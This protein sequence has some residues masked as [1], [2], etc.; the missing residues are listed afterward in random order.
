P[1][2][3]RRDGRR[4]KSCWRTSGA[5]SIW[6]DRRCGSARSTPSSTRPERAEEPSRRLREPRVV[7]GAGGR[8][9]GGGSA[10]ARNWRAARGL[11]RYLGLSARRA[12]DIA[13]ALEIR[14]AAELREAA[15]AGRLREV[16]GVG[17]KIEARIVAAL[18]RETEA[19]SPRGLWL[20]RARDLVCGI[21]QAL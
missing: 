5:S 6:S 12:L 20:N 2:R 11:G 13:R 19:R 3:P 18:G 15:A 4:R 1:R 21:A 14:T 17:P 9:R 7:P 8:R 10:R 16:P